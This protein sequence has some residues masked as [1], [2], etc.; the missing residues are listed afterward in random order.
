VVNEDVFESERDVVK[1]EYRQG[2]LASP[3][4][5][6][7]SDNEMRAGLPVCGRTAARPKKSVS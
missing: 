7:F 1:E 6:L 4:G 5:R 2:V 3:Y